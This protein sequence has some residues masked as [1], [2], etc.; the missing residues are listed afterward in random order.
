M[1]S[2]LDPAWLRAAGPG[3]FW[4]VAAVLWSLTALSLLYGART[5]L[6]LR[7]IANI[8]RSLIRSAA[9]GQVE[10]EGQARLMPGPP[11]VAP[12]SGM[13]CVWWSYTIH[14][15]SNR[16]GTLDGL[17]SDTS[18]DLFLVDDGSGQCV[19][20]PDDAEVYPSVT[21][22]WHGATP[23]PEGGPHMAL[24]GS[25]TYTERRIHEG[26]PLRAQGYFHTQGPVS[27]A[28]IDEEVRQQLAEWKRDQAWLIQHFDANHDGQ[29]DQ[30]EWDVARQ[31]AR[32]LIL[33]KERENLKRPPVNVVGK[34]RDGRAFVLSTEPR[35]KLRARLQRQM[36]AGLLAFLC[37]G[38]AATH[39]LS[40]RFTEVP[41]V[42]T[43]AP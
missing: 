26:D 22:V 20:D 37:L 23:M 3:E 34:P 10:L 15:P 41:P 39:M 1:F 2:F 27:S 43:A 14:G 29:V 38:A 33:E 25:Y 36:W 24:G 42:T 11:I 18:G 12:L 32:R 28:D 7:A 19:V 17:E 8:P 31:E 40:V 13:R 4:F 6:R 9:Q 16:T 30:Q 21:D 5:W 35:Q